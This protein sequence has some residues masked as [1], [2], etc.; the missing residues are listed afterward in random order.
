M[1]T[2]KVNILNFNI[3]IDN[4][5]AFCNILGFIKHF[6]IFAIRERQHYNFWIEMKELK[7]IKCLMSKTNITY[8]VNT[9]ISV[10]LYRITWKKALN[11]FLF[12]SYCFHYTVLYIN[13]RIQ[14]YKLKW[15]KCKV[16]YT[17]LKYEKLMNL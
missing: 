13:V 6:H 10:G 15:E 7:S 5:L 3:I 12:V 14:K 4:P 1:H 2:C 8:L 16:H 17:V 9:M 11:F